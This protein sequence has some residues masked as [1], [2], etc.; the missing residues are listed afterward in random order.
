MNPDTRQKVLIRDKNQ[1]QL[2]K[3]F[4]ISHLS[5]VPCIEETE[6]HHKTY[7]RFN[8]EFE[9][10]LIT[11]CRR[12]HDFLTSY[13]RSL[14][15]TRTNVHLAPDTSEHE[16]DWPSVET[17]RIRSEDD[18]IQA[19]GSDATDNAQW[20]TGRSARRIRE[21]NSKNLPNTK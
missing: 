14:R 18:R 13:I 6:V 12:C 11:V 8:D 1:C 4:G 15:F 7:E 5:G 20:P 3:I 9:E 17:Q 21:S 2:D 10:D 16:S 19:S